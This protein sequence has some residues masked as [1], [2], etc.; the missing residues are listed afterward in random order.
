[1]DVLMIFLALDI[2]SS[3]HDLFK[4]AKIFD[5]VDESW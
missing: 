2:K 3:I 1:M 5:Y 4:H